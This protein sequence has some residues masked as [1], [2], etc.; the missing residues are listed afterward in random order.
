MKKCLTEIGVYIQRLPFPIT[1]LV[2]SV[3]PKTSLLPIFVF[4]RLLE[5]ADKDALRPI[6]EA[7]VA[8]WWVIQKPVSGR[9]QFSFIPSFSRDLTFRGAMEAELEK[10][11]YSLEGTEQSRLEALRSAAADALFAGDEALTGE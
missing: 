10:F 5:P 3:F 11:Q 1:E 2:P 4:R 9:L 7:A 8:K 6:P